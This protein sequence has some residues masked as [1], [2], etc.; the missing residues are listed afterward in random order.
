MTKFYLFEMKDHLVCLQPLQIKLLYYF[1]FTVVNKTRP[2]QN[3]LNKVA[4]TYP[5]G[6]SH[7][8][9]LSSPQRYLVTLQ[10]VIH[11]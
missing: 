2:E 5:G 9:C 1:L 8:T 7:V 11:C 4:E 6:N 3:S 10:Q